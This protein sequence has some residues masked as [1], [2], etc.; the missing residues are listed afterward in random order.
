MFLSLEPV[1]LL[2]LK[3]G[4]HQPNPWTSEAFGESRMRSGTRMFG[5]FS[6]VGSFWSRVDVVCSYSTCEV[7]GGGPLDSFHWILWLVVCQLNGGSDWWRASESAR[8]VGGAEYRVRF[9]FLCSPFRHSPFSCFE[10]LARLVVVSVQ[11]ELMCV[12]LV[13]PAACSVCSWESLCT[14]LARPTH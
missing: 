14:D 10:L 11:E 6:C 8:C 7:W 4:T 12:C 13:M 1:C 9:V 3:A 5:V 2:P